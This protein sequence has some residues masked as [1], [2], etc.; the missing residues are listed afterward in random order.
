MNRDIKKWKAG[1]LHFVMVEGQVYV[2]V[3]DMIKN[4]D[5]LKIAFTR[6]LD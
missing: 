4:L 3:D 2:K 5:K 6:K 1:R